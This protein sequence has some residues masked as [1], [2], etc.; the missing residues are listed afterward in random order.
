[1]EY[2]AQLTA[3]RYLAQAFADQ[4]DEFCVHESELADVLISDGFKDVL[5]SFMAR[6]Y[7]RLV[8]FGDKA[9]MRQM[10]VR[11]PLTEELYKVAEGELA[12]MALFRHTAQVQQVPIIEL[13]QLL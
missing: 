6:K 13:G 4:V 3:V 12:F 11:N 1:M 9:P 7:C 5:N 10:G 2:V 8:C